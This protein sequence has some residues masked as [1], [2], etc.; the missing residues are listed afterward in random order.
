MLS[1]FVCLTGKGKETKKDL[2]ASIIWGEILMISLEAYFELLIAGY[3]NFSFQLHTTNGEVFA[4]YVAY[5][6]LILSLIV[7]PF[8]MIYI[9]FQK[10]DT[11]QDG[12]L[13]L[14]ELKQGVKNICLFEIL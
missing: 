10:M 11:N 4:I 3:L 5:Y 14:E 2:V 7:L 13:S 9:A 6:C 8:V 12:T 1:F